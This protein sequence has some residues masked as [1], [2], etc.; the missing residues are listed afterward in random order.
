MENCDSDDFPV[1]V[2]TNEGQNDVGQDTEII[3]DLAT[4]NGVLNPN[5]NDKKERRRG[6]IGKRRLNKA[7]RSA[8][9]KELNAIRRSR[10]INVYDE[11]EVFM[12][13]IMSDAAAER[14]AIDASSDQYIRCEPTDI[15]EVSTSIQVADEFTDSRNLCFR[16]IATQTD[17]V[18]CCCKKQV[19]KRRKPGRK[20]KVS[21]ATAGLLTKNESA[22]EMMI[23]KIKS[24]EMSQEINKILDT[25]KNSSMYKTQSNNIKKTK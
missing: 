23:S 11:F 18:L 19:S 8:R 17:D 9:A 25:G 14:N 22:N 15:S 1:I 12:K 7:E 5:V 13:K 24:E 4:D 21:N 16:T 6:M 20:V 2:P 3:V 10:I